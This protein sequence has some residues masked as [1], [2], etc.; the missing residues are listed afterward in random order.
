M[1]IRN[2]HGWFANQII[3]VCPPVCHQICI[4]MIDLVTH[5]S[6]SSPALKTH[7]LPAAVPLLLVIL[8]ARS[9]DVATV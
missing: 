1:S 7:Q 6:G 8:N 4:Y 5:L 9:H 3:I 2:N